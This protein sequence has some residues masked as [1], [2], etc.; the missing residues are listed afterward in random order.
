MVD[1][2]L[3]NGGNATISLENVSPEDVESLDEFFEII[4]DVLKKGEHTEIDLEITE[5]EEGCSLIE[6][7]EK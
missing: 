5:P 4:G 3:P 2:E 1:L 6:E 7:L